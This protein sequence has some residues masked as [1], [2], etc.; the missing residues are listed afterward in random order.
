MEGVYSGEVLMKNPIS[1]QAQL[2][3]EFILDSR[4]RRVVFRQHSQGLTRIELR[5]LEHFPQHEGCRVPRLELFQTVWGLG[6][7][8]R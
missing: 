3:Q 4:T 2:I 7:R 8:F 6:Y 1:T 5:F